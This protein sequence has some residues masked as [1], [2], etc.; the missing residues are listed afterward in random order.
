MAE[1]VSLHAGGS[2]GYE[3][4]A[5]VTWVRPT[6]EVT[7]GAAA[8]SALWGQFLIRDCREASKSV[9]SLAVRAR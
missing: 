3:V 4:G 1:R 7:G 2:Q 6:L 9:D 8:W 5:I